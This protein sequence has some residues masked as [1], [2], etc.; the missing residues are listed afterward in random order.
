MKR[1]FPR[2]LFVLV[3]LAGCSSAP[4]QL[5]PQTRVRMSSKSALEGFADA[6]P[7]PS[8]LARTTAENSEVASWLGDDAFDPALPT[9]FSALLAEQF[10]STSVKAVKLLRADVGV[11]KGDGSGRYN[12]SYNNRG[13]PY[14][15]PG[16]PPGA[17]ALGILLGEGLVFL[18]ANAKTISATNEVPTEF[19]TVYV[20][21]E[22]DGEKFYA[23]Q[24]VGKIAGT[25]AQKSLADALEVSARD[26]VAQH[27]L[28][29]PELQLK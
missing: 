7:V 25:T 22:I 19:W 23:G 3:V 12:T 28:R 9:I 26:I 14:I 1:S 8:R 18:A 24:R 11:T 10:G 16:A 20:T 4:P 29:F 5:E 13:T 15:P 21:V 2:A 17:V 27:R 6:R